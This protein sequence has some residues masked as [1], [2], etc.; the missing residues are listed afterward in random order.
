M[1]K[2]GWTV[3]ADAQPKMAST[4]AARTTREPKK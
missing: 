2:D 4:N 1:Q 3:E